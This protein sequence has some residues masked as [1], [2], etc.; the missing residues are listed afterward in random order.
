MRD[1]TWT[2]LKRESLEDLKEG[3]CLRVTGDGVPTFYV[4]VNPQ[5]MMRDRVEALCGLIDAGRGLPRL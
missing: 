3:Q 1:I 4:V 5:G 2:N